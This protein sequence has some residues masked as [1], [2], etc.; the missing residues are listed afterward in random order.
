MPAETPLERGA[1]VERAE[2]P[3]VGDRALEV[4]ELP[5]WSRARDDG[6]DRKNPPP[7][8]SPSVRLQCFGPQPQHVSMNIHVQY[9]GKE[10]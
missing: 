8:T 3:R 9:D 4:R 1:E 6:S 2:L 10:N 5:A 7:L